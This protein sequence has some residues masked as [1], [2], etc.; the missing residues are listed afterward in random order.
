MSKPYLIYCFTADGWKP[1]QF[2][3]RSKGTYLVCEKSEKTA[4]QA[5]QK[6]IGFGSIH[7]NRQILPYNSSSKFPPKT[8]PNCLEILAGRLK[9]GDIYK[10][11]SGISTETG[12]FTRY[13]EDPA[14]CLK[15]LTERS[16][17]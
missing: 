7:C 9:P 4:I 11:R 12:K 5:L 3:H 17:L 6:A 13:L 1:T 10:L 15:P 8:K 16:T 14:H 2:I